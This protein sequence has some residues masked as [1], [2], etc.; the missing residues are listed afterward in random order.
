MELS[1]LCSRIATHSARS[2]DSGTSGSEILR[3]SA[4]SSMPESASILA[5][6]TNLLR[7]G[8]ECGE[9]RRCD[10]HVR[11][12]RGSVAGPPVGRKGRFV[13][14][15]RHRLD[16]GNPQLSSPAVHGLSHPCQST[17]PASLRH[18][19]PAGGHLP[20]VDAGVGR[21]P[22]ARGPVRR[23]RGSDLGGQ[24]RGFARH[25]SCRGW[26]CITS[27]SGLFAGGGSGR[28]CWRLRIRRLEWVSGKS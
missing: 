20:G 12:R 18:R 22:R 7:R 14:S 23:A 26:S 11:H 6:E 21:D 24:A 3:R 2:A 5:V 27:T 16:P 1:S 15:S 4:S 25:Q 19:A 17:P 28:R 13:G 9:Q 10:E 8:H